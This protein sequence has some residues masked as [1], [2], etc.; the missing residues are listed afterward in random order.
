METIKHSM[1]IP[2]CTEEEI[3]PQF[4]RPVGEVRP[5]PPRPAK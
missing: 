2:L 1:V 4:I 3:F 5:V